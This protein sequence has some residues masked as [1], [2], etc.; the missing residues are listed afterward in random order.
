VRAGLPE[1]LAEQLTAPL[2]TPGWPVKPGALATNPTTFT[3]RTTES[4]PT[5]ASTA[6]SA[7]SVQDRAAAFPS[8]SETSAPTLPDQPRA[9]WPAV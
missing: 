4:S 7:L 6:A 3:T 9:T 1:D 8:A 2:I 5:S